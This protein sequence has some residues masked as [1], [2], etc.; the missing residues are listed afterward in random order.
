MPTS[1]GMG[2]S[3]GGTGDTHQFAPLVKAFNKGGEVQFIHTEASNL[4]VAS[5]LT[6]M[7]G[8]QVV[9]VPSLAQV[10]ESL[11]AD[12]YVFTNG[13]QGTG[14]FGFQAD[15][16]DSVPG[17]GGYSPLRQVNLVAWKAGATPREFRSVEEV[18]SAESAG[19]VTIERPGVVVNM[20]I[21]AWPGGQR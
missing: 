13:V 3:I 17:D 5:M 12:V 20:P 10:P 21:L 18:K 8:P 7:M 11:L 6:T 2:I 19:D 14:P 16:F 4:Q 1:T 15:V 9:L